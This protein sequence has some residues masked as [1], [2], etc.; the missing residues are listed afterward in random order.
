MDV[1]LRVV[2]AMCL[3]GPAGH[4]AAQSAERWP[5]KP[6]RLVVPFAPGGSS[7]IIARS[8]AARLSTSLGQQVFVENK[9]GAA[10]N[11]RWRT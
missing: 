2:V 3:L 8:L 1:L 11:V 7:E 10:G 4:A 6:I 5:T 9:P